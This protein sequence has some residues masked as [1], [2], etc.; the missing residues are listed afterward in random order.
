MNRNTSEE[1]ILVVFV[2]EMESRGE[3]RM[4]VRLD[5][6]ESMMERINDRKGSKVD[7]E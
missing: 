3:N 4:L 5:I 7:L 6:D 1:D 2:E